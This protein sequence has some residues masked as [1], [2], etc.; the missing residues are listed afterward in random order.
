MGINER[1]KTKC[2]SVSA[3]DP[4][5]LS[6]KTFEDSLLIVQFFFFFFF[7]WGGGGH[8][9]TLQS[10]KSKNTSRPTLFLNTTVYV[11]MIYHKHNFVFIL[12]LISPNF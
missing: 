1:P 5:I 2:I 8:R 7:F 10:K 4:R 9:V 3:S 6:T 11:I 12:K